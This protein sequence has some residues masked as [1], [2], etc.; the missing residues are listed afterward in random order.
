MRAYVA[1]VKAVVGGTRKC[2][3]AFGERKL[4]LT[5]GPIP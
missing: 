3:C 4:G 5:I 2:A 1:K